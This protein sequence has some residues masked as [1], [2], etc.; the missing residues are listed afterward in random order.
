VV[1]VEGQT[2]SFKRSHR[3]DF[4]ERENR[5]SYG[6][7]AAKAS[8]VDGQ[9]VAAGVE[10]HFNLLNRSGHPGQPPRPTRALRDSAMQRSLRGELH[11][12]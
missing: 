11:Q 12:K 5:I 7:D 10:E 4:I 8:V 3:P 9:I 2:V 6:H 1:S